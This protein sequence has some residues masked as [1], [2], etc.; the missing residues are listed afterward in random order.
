MDYEV[1]LR[2]EVMEFLR[3][4]KRTER[5]ELLEILTKLGSDPFRK[6]DFMEKDRAGR[7]IQAVI[8]RRFA[9]GPI[10]RLRK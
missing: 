10:T 5:E 1:Y 6:G 4:R 2:R 7:E 3:S 8:H 9:I